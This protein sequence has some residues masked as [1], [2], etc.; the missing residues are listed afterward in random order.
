MSLMDF[1]NADGSY[2][3]TRLEKNDGK[4]YMHYL[5]EKDGCVYLTGA[6]KGK[7]CVVMPEE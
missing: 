3:Q 4:T 5:D 6:R 1:N 7:I 2:L